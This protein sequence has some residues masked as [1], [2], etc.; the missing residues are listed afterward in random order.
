[1]SR[2]REIIGRCCFYYAEN[3]IEVAAFYRLVDEKLVYCVRS[4]GALPGEQRFLVNVVPSIENKSTGLRVMIHMDIGH[5]KFFG[6]GNFKIKSGRIVR[7]TC[8]N[9]A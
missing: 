8:L 9:G 6:T 5:E 3:S 1:M 7:W 4:D 2:E